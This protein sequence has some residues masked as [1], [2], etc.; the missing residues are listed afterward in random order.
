MSDGRT[1]IASDTLHRI[2]SYDFDT[3]EDTTIISE[4]SSIMYF[5]LDRTEEHCLVTTRKEGLHLWCMKTQTLVRTFLGSVHNDYVVSSTF[6]GF[7][8]DFIATGSEGK[9]L[10]RW[11]EIKSI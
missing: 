4:T 1:V 8:G 5:T 6:G 11:R 3:Q 2:R 10:V 9:Y 7:S